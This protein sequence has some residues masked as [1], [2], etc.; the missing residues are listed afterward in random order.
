MTYKTPLNFSLCVIA[1]I[2]LLG[3]IAWD[4]LV[5]LGTRWI[6]DEAYSHG[7]ILAALVGYLVVLEKA[8]LRQKKLGYSW[9]A[10]IGMCF[11][12]AV[13]LVSY[14]TQI[15]TLQYQ[16]FLVTMAFLAIAVMGRAS[17][18][19]LLPASL[20]VFAI[21]LPYFTQVALTADLQLISS[22]IAAFS[23]RSLGIP[24]LLEGNII[25]MGN[26]SLQVV[27]A[28][29][30]LNYLVPL[31]GLGHILAYMFKTVMWKR[32][33]LVI[34][35]IPISVFLNSTRITIT[36]YM[37]DAY[38]INTAEGFFHAFQ[39][40][41]I[42]VISMFVLGVEMI[43]LNKIG[44]KRVNLM[45]TMGFKR[46]GETDGTNNPEVEIRKEPK[47]LFAVLAVSVLAAGLTFYFETKPEFIPDRAQLVVFPEKIDQW[48]GRMFAGSI[49]A[50]ETL[51]ADDH[52]FANYRL[53]DSNKLVELYVA[54]FDR[55]SDDKNPHSPKACL[56]GGG[57]DIVSI[58]QVVK[59]IS[60]TESIPINRMVI[61]KG[62]HK[63]LLYYWFNLHG[64]QI[65]DEYQMKAHMLRDRVLLNR[66]DG[67]IIRI[68]SA[69]YA[70]E[71]LEAV[72]KRMDEFLSSLNPVLGKFIPAI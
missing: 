49:E 39:G 57:W 21:P 10:F 62:T 48:E 66:S 45:E 41:L 1:T 37:F 35:A 18:V 67:A 47:T 40:W 6:D 51:G 2:A 32:V 28:C 11:F 43:L 50:M 68:T 3:F 16:S 17:V 71:S 56:P 55:Q 64:R 24:V 33:L 53:K 44:S 31:L 36:G 29:A 58:E 65:A 72:E 70:G 54:Y 59:N 23:L 13:L 60:P 46:P 19:I 52:L 69:N 63:Q 27:E 5:V 61:Q 20:L 14:I 38:D 8:S 22:E 15:Q 30:G 26:Y 42:F 4:G 7:F 25:D 12:T 34:S 9:I